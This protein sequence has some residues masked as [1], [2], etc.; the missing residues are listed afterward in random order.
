METS[1][2]I[3]KKDMIT[4]YRY[5]RTFLLV[6]KWGLYVLLLFLY[7]YNVTFLLITPIMIYGGTALYTSY[8]NL[9]RIEKQI[10]LLDQE[11]FLGRDLVS[12]TIFF[13]KIVQDYFSHERR[14]PSILRKTSTKEQDTKEVELKQETKSL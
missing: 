7:F 14:I 4:F 3:R 2:D 9:E 12:A 1:N 10:T 6:D 5:K 8:K 11:I 13:A